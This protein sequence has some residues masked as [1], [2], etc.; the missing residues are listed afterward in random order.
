MISIQESIERLTQS[1]YAFANDRLRI[2]IPAA[3]E[4][5]LA[6]MKHFV[7]DPVW[8]DD[9]DDVAEWLTDSHGKGLLLIGDCGLGKT[10][11]ATC[12][13]PVIIHRNIRKIFACY[14]AREINKKEKDIE[15][16]HLIIIDDIG[17]ED[18]KNNYGEKKGVFSSIVDCAERRGDI[19]II[20]TNLTFKDIEKKY[21]AR[22][23]DRLKAI[24]KWVVFSG[25]SFRNNVNPNYIK[26]PKQ[27][28]S[29]CI[30]IN[31]IG[32]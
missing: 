21:G 2:S 25:K 13:L 19:L 10:L 14:S 20:T 6:V 8:S 1:G 11:L 17:V 15:N 12:V 28:N 16:S 31:K 22:T 26:M 32:A 30:P 5:M 4:Q 7:S 29:K 3:K 24:T 9:Y 18:I 23:L 27:S